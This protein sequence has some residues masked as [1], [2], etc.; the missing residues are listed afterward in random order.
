[1]IKAKILFL[2]LFLILVIS[3]TAASQT[4]KWVDEKGVSHFSD[5]RPGK[6]GS[7][8][9]VK[10]IPTYRSRSKSE[11]KYKSRYQD[12]GDASYDKTSAYGKEQDRR[13]PEVELYVTSW[14]PYCNKARNYFQSRGIP[15]KVY[16]IEKDKRAA[17][18]KKRLDYRKGVPFAV[19]NGQRIHG[20]AVSAY[21]KALQMG[22]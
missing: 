8:A 18:R 2:F 15:F 17:E 14:C 21:E 16:D 5:Q 3:G 19:I 20:Y 4:Y 10:I 22:K 6:S 9:K 12:S 11:K 7:S 1:M 13:G